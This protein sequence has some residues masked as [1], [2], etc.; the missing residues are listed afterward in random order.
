MYFRAWKPWEA[1]NVQTG[2]LWHEIAGVATPIS[3]V[4][5]MECTLE[6]PA[7]SPSMYSPLTVEQLAGWKSCLSVEKAGPGEKVLMGEYLADLSHR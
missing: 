5:D 6:N 7:A 1:L 3:T 2:S 4:L